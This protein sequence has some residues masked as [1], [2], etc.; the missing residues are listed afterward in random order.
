MNE[1]HHLLVCDKQL[2]PC[3]HLAAKAFA[4]SRGTP[5]KSPF[6][7]RYSVKRRH[8]IH[9]EFVGRVGVCCFKSCLERRP[10]LL[11]ATVR[12]KNLWQHD[13]LDSLGL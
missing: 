4:S 12:D 6:Y 3:L 13:V 11:L 1:F 10:K 9:G 5:G 8:Q 7:Y 2:T